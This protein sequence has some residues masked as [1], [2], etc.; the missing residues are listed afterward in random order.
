MIKISPAPKITYAKAAKETKAIKSSKSTA[1]SISKKSADCDIC[2]KL[3]PSINWDDFAAD[4]A[5]GSYWLAYTIWY[6]KYSYS[7]TYSKGKN[8]INLKSECVLN[9]S[10]SW[11]KVKSERLLDHERGHYL[12]GWAC[13]LDFKRRVLATDFSNSTRVA[14][15]TE[16]K[17]IF[18][19]TMSEYVKWEKL[20]DDETDH[21]LDRENQKY[22]DLMIWDKLEGLRMYL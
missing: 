10:K 4:P 3:I 5:E 13:A 9:K 20:Y 11:V 7:I 12:I 2:G 22:W 8:V 15:D 1:P 6:V 21:Y 16:I 17:R 18:K 19:E 14:I